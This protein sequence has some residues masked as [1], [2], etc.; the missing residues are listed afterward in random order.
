MILKKETNKQANKTIN[1]AKGEEKGIKGGLRGRGEI[2]MR[3]FTFSVG[4]GKGILL[5]NFVLVD[6]IVDFRNSLHFFPNSTLVFNKK[7]VS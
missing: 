3:D 7:M 1:K 6:L 4:N 5:V 2:K